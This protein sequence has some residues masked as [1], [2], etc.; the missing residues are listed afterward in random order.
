M[1][2][3]KVTLRF[4]KLNP[5]AVVPV[6]ATD[7]SAGIDFS[8]CWCKKNTEYGY[9]EYGTGIAVEI[10]EGY[11][12]L[13]FPRS[14]VSKTNMSLANCVGVID[15]DYRGEVTARF[16]EWH[17]TDE[18]DGQKADSYDVGHRIFQM[19]LVANPKVTLQETD[20][21]SSTVRGE[22]GYG[23]TGR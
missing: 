16:R 22:G 10:P 5:E 18:Y 19:V 4:K 23:S 15:S 8:S 9:W 3:A 17:F 21:L 14:S 2:R 6:M 11:V 7:G 1:E 12:G 20:S 13:C